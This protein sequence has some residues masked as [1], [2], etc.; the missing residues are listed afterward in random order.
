MA[1]RPLAGYPMQVGDKMLMIFDIDGPTSY[2]NTGTF[3]TSGQQ[4]NAADLGVGGFE[5][6]DP[7][8][9]SN[10][11]VASGKI[12]LGAATAGTTALSPSPSVGQSGPAVTTAVLHWY[13][14]AASS[15]EY[16]NGTNLSAKSLR[17]EAFVV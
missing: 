17:M 11:G 5:T 12:V 1:I 8:G 6:M 15:T 13:N 2:V 4:I 9:L 10:D 14:S 3:G 16:T 7:K